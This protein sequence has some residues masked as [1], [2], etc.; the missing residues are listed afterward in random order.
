MEGISLRRRWRCW[1][2]LVGLVL[3]FAPAAQAESVGLKDDVQLLAQVVCGEARSDSY[4]AKVAIAAVV[5]NRTRD[6]RFPESVA[7]VVYQTHA[8]PTV[9]SGKFY[10]DTTPECYRAA[11]A[12][13]R[14]LD[15]TDGALYVLQ[16]DAPRQPGAGRP[17]VRQIGRL[18][19][20]R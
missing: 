16:G 18:K 14:G 15:P 17:I 3:L 7:G 10:R 8:F 1:P 11:R 6:P 2:C 4:E 13:L 9:R 5:L 12:A 19:F 20:A